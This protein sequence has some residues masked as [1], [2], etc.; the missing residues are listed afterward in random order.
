MGN[1]R[2][3]RSFA[4][5]FERLSPTKRTHCMDW[6]RWVC[7]QLREG[8]RGEEIVEALLLRIRKTWFPEDS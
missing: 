2:K 6:L 4:Q 8:W 1:N 7:D 5:E 3:H